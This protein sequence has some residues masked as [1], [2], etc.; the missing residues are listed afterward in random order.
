MHS[1]PAERD[2]KPGP[3][4]DEPVTIK[5]TQR[6]SVTT[7]GSFCVMQFS[8]WLVNNGFVC[9]VLCSLFS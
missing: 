9:W 4:G 5:N 2:A 1:R 3:H 8:Y 6:R 7:N